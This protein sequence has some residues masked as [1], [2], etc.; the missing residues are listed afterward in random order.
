LLERIGLARDVVM[1]SPGLTA[2]TTHL[3]EHA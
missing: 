2:L 1:P 3:R